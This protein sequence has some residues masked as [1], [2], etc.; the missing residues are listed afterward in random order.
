MI[1]FDGDDG[2]NSTVNVVYRGGVTVWSLLIL[3]WLMTNILKPIR[4]RI[5]NRRRVAAISKMEED[6][7]KMQQ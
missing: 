4:R 6:R 5:A 1:S 2:Q 3:G 7:M